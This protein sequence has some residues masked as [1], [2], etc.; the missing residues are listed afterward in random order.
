MKTNQYKA[1]WTEQDE[2][3]LWQARIQL[4]KTFESKIPASEFYAIQDRVRTL[5]ERKRLATLPEPQITISKSEHAALE[6]VAEWAECAARVM[7][8]L[9]LRP[10]HQ[11]TATELGIALANLAAVRSAIAKAKGEA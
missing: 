4:D 6:A 5:A 9:D 11:S 8:S 2:T 7:E 10:A 3:S 1:T